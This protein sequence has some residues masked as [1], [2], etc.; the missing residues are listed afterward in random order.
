MGGVVLSNSSVDCRGTACCR[1]GERGTTLLIMLLMLLMI[2]A[3]GIGTMQVAS[4]EIKM[5]HHHRQLWR[6]SLAADGVARVTFRELVELT[7]SLGRF[8]SDAEL[9]L[10]EAPSIDGIEVTSFAVTSAGGAVL[11]PLQTGYYQGLTAET[12]SFDVELTLKTTDTVPGEASISMG[13]LFDRIPILQFALFYGHDLELLPIDQMRIEGRVHGNGDIYVGSTTD[14]TIDSRITS[15]GD[16][17]NRRKDS[18]AAAGSRVEFRDE[19][20]LSRAM[21]GLDSSSAN[22]SSEALERWGGN[23]LSQEHGVQPLNLAIADQVNPRKMIEPGYDDDSPDDRATKLFYESSMSINIL[24]G[25]AFDQVGNEIPLLDALDFTVIFDHRE[26]RPML[27]VELDLV[28][29]ANL[30]NF[31]AGPTVLYV[32]S[33]RP[34]NGIPD[35]SVTSPSAA[36]TQNSLQAIVDANPGTPLADKIEDVVGKLVTALIECGKTPPDIPAAAGNINGAIVDLNAAVNDGLLD[37]GEAAIYE[38]Q[39]IPIGNCEVDGTEADWPPVWEDY[40]P[41]YA[42][43][44]TE[45]AVKLSNGAELPDAFTVVSANA[46]YVHGDYNTE[47]KKPAAVLADAITILSNAWGND[48][49]AYSQLTLVDRPAV[50]TTVNASVITGTTETLPGQYN[51]GA[52]NLLRFL[53]DWSNSTL[54]YRGSFVS[55]WYSQQAIGR[56][57]VGFPV[58]EVPTRDWEF[59]ADLLDPE[60]LP[61]ATPSVY[62]LR[63]AR[64]QR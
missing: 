37:A 64:W 36:E 29:L 42:G 5:A 30:P 10:I 56:W 33:F 60:K 40:A 62:A 20:G 22:W 15:A 41:P 26:Q 45:F 2:S 51:G 19:R 55:L 23:V 53:E 18:A 6:A 47:N 9:Q 16:I 54:T 39:L 59:D 61:P 8:P 52:E 27:T 14:L 44:N 4:T 12:E 11:E 57:R 43:G 24:N 34:G 1:A 46:V 28:K 38:A 21:G 32:G 35:W 3:I 48:D 17:F 63:L 31:A 7:R 25:Q 13:V 50:N 58:Y 49:L